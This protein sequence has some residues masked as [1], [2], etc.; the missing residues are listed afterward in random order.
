MH[1]TIRASRRRLW[2][3]AVPAAQLIQISSPVHRYQTGVSC[4]NPVRRTV[5]TM[6]FGIVARNAS[7]R[8]GEGIIGSRPQRAVQPPSIIWA[9]PV[10]PPAASEQRKRT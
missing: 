7:W 10:M 8:S 6:T 3:L 2:T 1:R 9:D 4:G 5:A